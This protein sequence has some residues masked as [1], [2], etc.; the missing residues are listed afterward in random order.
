MVLL[1]FKFALLLSISSCFLSHPGAFWG[2]FLAPIIAVMIF[3]MVIFIWVIVIL[4]RHT[5]GVAVQKKEALSKKTILRLMISIGGVMFLF[6]L[7][8]LFA[9]LTFSAPGLRETFQALF[10]VSNSFQGFFIFLFFCVFNKEAREHWKELLSCGRYTSDFL[11]PSHA[12]YNSSTGTGV[13]K[14]KKVTT[15]TRLSSTSATRAAYASETITKGSNVYESGTIASRLS[16]G[17]AEKIPLEYPEAT[18]KEASITTTVIVETSLYV[19]T[20]TAD[21]KEDLSQQ[22]NTKH[23]DTNSEPSSM[24]GVSEP[25]ENVADVESPFEEEAP[26]VHQQESDIKAI[27]N[28]SSEDA[29]GVNNGNETANMTNDHDIS[30]GDIAIQVGKDTMDPD[31]RDKG[32]EK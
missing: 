20:S 29:Y 21:D 31:A 19:H 12:K 26:I 24:E 8:W 5:R 15:S 11:H 3:N 9:I 10:T 22:G 7:T 6:G 27:K 1:L 28:L 13:R 30:S 16:A 25:Q 23:S 4:L 17:N 14:N 2:A 32:E 18:Q